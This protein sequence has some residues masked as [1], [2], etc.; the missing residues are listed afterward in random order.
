VLIE[1]AWPLLCEGVGTS[2]GESEMI[3]MALVL[4]A[5]AWGGE[6]ELAAR[7]GFGGQQVV[8]RW[9]T[10]EGERGGD[11]G[12]YAS[13]THTGSWTDAPTLVPLTETVAR[14]ALIGRVGFHGE[15]RIAGRLGLSSG[16]GLDLAGPVYLVQWADRNDVPPLV[17]LAAAPLAA[18]VARLLLSEVYLMP[19]VHVGERLEVEAGLVASAVPSVLDGAMYPK[20]TIGRGWTDSRQPWIA[21]LNP[22]VGLTLRL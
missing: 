15:R 20:Q 3:G 17:G 6:G 7:A 12:F 10:E 11:F 19:T 9:L 1:V 18:Q 8:G 16:V 5:V 13:V 21:I 4:G 14:S 2:T 22:S